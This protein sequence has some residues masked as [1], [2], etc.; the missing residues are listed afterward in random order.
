MEGRPARGATFVRPMVRS[1]DPSSR[2]IS[3]LVMLLC[4][5]MVERRR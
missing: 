5:E 1:L 3:G 4:C 2:C